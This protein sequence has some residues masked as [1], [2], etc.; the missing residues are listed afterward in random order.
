MYVVYPL[1]HSFSVWQQGSDVPYRCRHECLSVADLRNRWGK[2]LTKYR[3]PTLPF[4]LTKQ[5]YVES[6]AT[7]APR[8]PFS[9]VV[10]LMLS[11]EYLTCKI[12]SCTWPNL[13]HFRWLLT[14]PI[15]KKSGNWR[16]HME[17]FV[18]PSPTLHTFWATIRRSA[19]EMKPKTRL[20]FRFPHLSMPFTYLAYTV[21]A[22]HCPQAC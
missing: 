13:K 3:S 21:Y 4:V 12:A 19:S 16:R 5:L 2:E 1:Q 9:A 8:P 14:W 7:F 20:D 6:V 15:A 22:H 18:S 17:A 11:M 10:R